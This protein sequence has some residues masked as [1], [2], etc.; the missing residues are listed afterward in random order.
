MI[1]CSRGCK[2]MSTSVF[3]SSSMRWTWS[4]T[5]C[6]RSVIFWSSLANSCRESGW[7]SFSCSSSEWSTVSWSC[8]MG[9]TFSRP[10][11]SE[12]DPE[13]ER[14]K[15]QWGNIVFFLA[16]L[17]YGHSHKPA[18][19]HF[20]LH[21]PLIVV[22]IW[23]QC[24]VLIFITFKVRLLSSRFMLKLPLDICSS[25]MWD[26]NISDSKHLNFITFASKKLRVRTAPD[27]LTPP[28]TCTFP[29]TIN[30]YK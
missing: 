29:F 12:Q 10:G 6:R 22:N 24:S 7:F 4:V 28:P 1:S 16:E 27:V 13:R 30:H 26:Y 17:H 14:K 8:S 15:T 25:D 19:L 21:S 2:N 18:Y 9:F 11:R 23:P 20:K 5:I 3:F